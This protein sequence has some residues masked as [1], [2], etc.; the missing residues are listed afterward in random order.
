MNLKKIVGIE[1]AK[2]VENGMVLGLGTGSTAAFFVEE[3]ARRVQEENLS[4]VAVTT[5][6]ATTVQAEKLGIRISSLDEISAIDLTVDG[7]DEFDPVLNGIKGGG[8]ALLMEKI[9]ATSSKDYIWIADASKKVQQLGK[10]PLP[11]EVVPFGAQLLFKKFESQGYQPR[12]RLDSRGELLLTDQKHFIIDLQLEKIENA[13]LLAQEL[14]ETVGIVEHGLFLNMA[15]RV[16]IAGNS[17]IQTF[18]K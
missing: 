6:S 16:I 13:K 3:V 5:S 2:Y 10:F 11:V 18:E 4:I 1:A 8:A 7:V 17:G 15:K 9:V 14:D 12:W